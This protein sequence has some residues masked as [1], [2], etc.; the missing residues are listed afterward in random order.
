MLIVVDVSEQKERERQL[1]LAKEQAEQNVRLKQEFLANMSHEIRTPMNSIIGFSRII[2]TKDADEEI[3][4]IAEIIYESTEDLLVIVNDILDFSKMDSGKLNLEPNHFLLR[5]KITRIEKMFRLKAKEKAI[6]F[7]CIVGEEVP[8]AVYG[9]EVRFAQLINNLV[10][11]AI[12]F[13]DDGSVRLKVHTEKQHADG[14]IL[15]MEISDTGVG[16][17]ENKI[18]DIFE[19]FVQVEGRIDRTKGG[20]GLGLAIVKKIVSLMGGTIKVDSTLGQGTTF[21]LSIPF[22]PGDTKLASDHFIVPDESPL[23]LKGVKILMAE[24]NRN[25]QI[26][27]KKICKDWGID[28]TVANNGQEAIDELKKNSTDYELILM[29]IQ[30]PVLDGESATRM[31]QDNH[32]WRQIPIVALTAHVL[33]KEVARLKKLGIL[34]FLFKP[35]KP[36]DLIQII[37]KYKR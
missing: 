37:R 18:V 13:T 26:L 23:D 6:S 31:I 5:D 8:E 20:T 15:N 33:E 21:S 25:N 12:K 34:G 3:H 19:S 16:I 28:L 36:I 7:E 2:L 24:D 4:E 22:K 14:V 11:N 29:D 9:D 32:E 35:F 1:Q 30:M 10:S 17:P 27:V